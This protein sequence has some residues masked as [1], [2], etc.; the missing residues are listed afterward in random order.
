MATRLVEAQPPYP[1]QPVE[2]IV[3]FAPGGGSD[4][5]GRLIAAYASRKWGHAVNVV[6]RPGASGITA[7]LHVLNASPDGYTLLVDAHGVSTMRFAV[8]SDVPFKMEG[9]TS[10]AL[11]TLDPVI[12]TVKHDSPWKTLQD[13]A[14]AAK[15]SPQTFR[16]GLGGVAGV[17]SFSVAQFLYAAGVPVAETNRVV[18]TG[19]YPAIVALA[20]GHVDFGGQQWSDSA[21]LIHAGKLRG[22]AV[23]HSRRLPGLPDVPTV[24]EAGFPDLDVVGW[25]GLSGPPKLPAHVVARWTALLERAS[26]DPVFLD[27]ALKA[28]KVVAY[29]GPEGFWQFQQEELRR[30]LPLAIKL[31]IRK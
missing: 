12:Y 29:K 16:Y 15:A 17:A 2:L 14:A 20:G 9:K 13:V 24:A 28:Q 8:Q 26:T 23:V 31:G 6:N 1:A 27:Q 25:H 21:D 18:F 4:V 7:T 3:G 30:Y 11:V 10:I 22:L 5:A 19:G